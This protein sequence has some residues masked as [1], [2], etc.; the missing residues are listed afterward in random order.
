[1]YIL[2]RF[3]TL[4]IAIILTLFRLVPCSRKR[5]WLCRSALR[6]QWSISY[7]AS[8][9]LGQLHIISY[10]CIWEVVV[11][12]VAHTM[13]L[14]S[15][16]DVFVQLTILCIYVPSSGIKADSI[17]RLL[18]P[19]RAISPMRWACEA[20]CVAEFKGQPFVAKDHARLLLTSG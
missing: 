10:T 17:P 8:S 11:S 7:W 12:H 20:L 1:M 16:Y 3:I 19:L 18:R 9:D 13:R 15:L 4:I 14:F 5:T 2:S 6:C